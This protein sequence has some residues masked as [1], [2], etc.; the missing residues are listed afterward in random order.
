MVS[1]MRYVSRVA[2]DQYG[3]P[4]YHP[5]VVVAAP[6]AIAASALSAGGAELSATAVCLSIHIG[7]ACEEVDVVQ[8]KIE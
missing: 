5:V 1:D 7:L 3:T 2:A 8:L 6:W 4:S